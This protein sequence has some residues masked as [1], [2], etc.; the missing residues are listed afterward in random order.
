MGILLE[1]KDLNFSYNDKVML[2]KLSFNV[3]KGEFISFLGSNN[4]GKTTLIKLLAGLLPS[5]NN[6]ELNKIVLNRKNG[7]KYLRS[8]GLV[9]D[10]LDRQFL[11]DS[12]REELRNVL[13]NLR[14]SKKKIEEK[15]AFI[16]DELDI[17]NILDEKIEDLGNFEKARV[18]M[19]VALVHDPKIIYVDDVFKRVSD[20]EGR[21]LNQLLRKM[22]TLFEI[23]IITTS[24][25]LGDSLYADR[26]ILLDKAKISLEGSF[27]EVAAKDNRLAKAGIVIPK[28]I[29][30][31]LK[32]QFYELLDKIITDEKAMVKKLWK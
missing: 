9:L 7:R 8:M 10:D 6:I 31:S 12:P 5:D 4:S 27:E 23:A 30:M 24:S 2:S 22:A 1:V 25:N 20:S 19:A 28:M 16:A 11:S 26:V 29:D 18:L 15:T 3:K 32:L 21:V 17:T 14:F 13:K